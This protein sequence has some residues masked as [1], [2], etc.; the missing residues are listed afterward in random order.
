[1]NLSDHENT[2]RSLTIRSNSLYSGEFTVSEDTGFRSG[3]LLSGTRLKAVMVPFLY[4]LIKHSPTAVAALPMRLLLLLV[5]FAYVLPNNPFRQSCENISTLAAA[6]GYRHSPKKIYRQLIKNANGMLTN[7]FRL[8]RHG[9]ESVID[10]IFIS[11]EDARRIN[12]LVND[13]GGAVLAVPHN[14]ASLFSALK[15]SRE[16]SLI[17]VTRNPSTIERTK[18]GVEFF[19]RMNV[20]ILMV[21]GGNPFELSRTLFSILKSGNTIAATVDSMDHSEAAVE[22]E[23][24]GQRVGFPTWAAKIAAKKRIPVIPSYFRSN[25]NQVTAV[26]G[27]ELISDSTEEI[28]QHYV[29]FFEKNILEDPASW[30]YLCDKRWSRVLKHAAQ[31]YLN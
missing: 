11:D 30:A 31:Q 28:V 8:Y 18:I 24:F 20:K 29:R 14:Y 3:R 26:Y 7:Y 16:F 23:I 9:V 1:M 2:S 10:R 4:K 17:C 15:M 22:V 25:G 6:Y 27:E 12:R 21:R 19:E 5:R 13:H